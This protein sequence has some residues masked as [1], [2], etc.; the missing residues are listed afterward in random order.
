MPPRFVAPISPFFSVIVTPA[1]AEEQRQAAEQAAKSA[2]IEALVGRSESI[3]VTQRD[4][5]ALLA[6]EAFRL[7]DTAQTRSALLSTFTDGEGFLDAHHFSNDVGG[8]SGIVLPN[9]ESAYYVDAAGR[10]RPLRS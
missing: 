8:R 5:A 6:V 1:T 3:Q 4:T 10:L 7:A 9:G 2:Q